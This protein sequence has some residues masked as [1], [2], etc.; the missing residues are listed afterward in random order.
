M[1][2]CV[3]TVLIIIIFKVVSSV[4]VAKNSQILAVVT[5]LVVVIGI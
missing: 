1:I 4:A 3:N 2:S 5:R